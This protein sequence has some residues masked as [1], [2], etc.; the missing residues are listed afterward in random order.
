MVPS[1]EEQAEERRRMIESR[2]VEEVSESSGEPGWMRDRRVK[3]WRIFEETPPPHGGEE[4]WRRTDVGKFDL[5]DDESCRCPGDA[6]TDAEVEAVR[7]L[8]LR[9][10]GAK[11]GGEVI[12]KDFR[13]KAVGVDPGAE[14][15]GVIFTELSSALSKHPSLMENFFMT[16][17]LQPER[18]RFDALHGALW[19][20][21]AFI[22]VPEGKEVALPLHALFYLQRERTAFFPHLLVVLERGS[23][24]TVYSEWR[25]ADSRE[26]M[27]CFP[28]IEVFVGEGAVFN[29]FG[30]QD[31]GDNTFSLSTRRVLAEKDSSILWVEG[32]LGG[33]LSKENLEIALNGP[34]AE[35]DLAG[36]FLTRG[37]Q[38]LDMSPVVHHIAPHTRGDVLINGALK[39][40]SRSIFH[41]MVR[42]DKSALYTDAHLSNHNLLLSP[43]ARADTIPKLEIECNEVR[44]SHGV[45]AGEMDREMLFYAMSRGLDEQAAKNLIVDGFYESTLQRIPHEGIREM[46]G[47]AVREKIGQ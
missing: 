24:A 40:E 13:A 29:Y 41:G 47:R 30:L 23:K 6:L 3:A 22:Y 11:Y 28:A 25:S 15:G 2:L 39:D 7:A 4:A 44:A 1:R 17:C 38:H 43:G 32:M 36:A 31:R 27:L 18:S 5:K 16:R 14:N 21:G 35:L 19:S 9:N 37:T 42:I 26:R 10:G 20:D 46:L 45:T 33:R 8:S 34:G 12:Q